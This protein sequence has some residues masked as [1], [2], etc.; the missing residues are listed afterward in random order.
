MALSTLG[1]MFTTGLSLNDESKAHRLDSP[2]HA[3]AIRA[4]ITHRLFWRAGERTDGTP[5]V[6]LF[7]L[8]NDGP[9]FAMDLAEFRDQPET[10]IVRQI[11]VTLLS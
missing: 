2:V 8:S 6:A 1:S 7:P 4:G 5:A 11:E 10:E 9:L 3:V